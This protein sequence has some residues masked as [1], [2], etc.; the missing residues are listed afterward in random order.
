MVFD[1]LLFDSSVVEAVRAIFWTDFES[2]LAGISGQVEDHALLTER[3]T[4]N[5]L[6]A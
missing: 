3:R 4:E 1:L 6:D 2:P 5:A